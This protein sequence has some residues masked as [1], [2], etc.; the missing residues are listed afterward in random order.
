[1]GRW[2]APHYLRPSLSGGRSPHLPLSLSLL[3]FHWMLPAYQGWLLLSRYCSP[4]PGVS[5]MAHRG[6]F[7]HHSAP[8]VTTTRPS[9]GVAACPSGA[10]EK[11]VSGKFPLWAPILHKKELSL[12]PLKGEGWSL[13]LFHSKFIVISTVIVHCWLLLPSY[14]ISQVPFI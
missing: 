2:T 4:L 6:W 9:A 8:F 1:M 12:S 7:A 3:G 14:I 11:G 10:E 13:Y 5:V